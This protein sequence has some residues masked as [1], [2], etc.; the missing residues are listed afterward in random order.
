M[1]EVEASPPEPATNNSSRPLIKKLK[2]GGI[3][4]GIVLLQC[5]FVSLWLPASDQHSAHASSKP[6]PRS[7]ETASTHATEEERSEV[8]LGAFSLTVFNPN[9]NANLLI[10]FHLFGTV[11][12]AAAEAS[13]EKAE[14]PA[15]G[16]ASKLQE[17][18]KK[19]KHRFRDQVIVTIRNS[20]I[21]D[22]TDPGLGLIKRQ[23]LAKT[24]ALL[25]E[26][27][28]KEVVFSDFVVVEQ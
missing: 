20:Q 24:N 6:E 11:A 25:G 10:D 22:L 21:A 7:Q 13:G 28:V 4:A 14:K 5:V 1:S 9:T 17:M 8:D 18:L 16:D 3:I 12:G 26:P 15:E 23:I 19:Q 27:L 2:V